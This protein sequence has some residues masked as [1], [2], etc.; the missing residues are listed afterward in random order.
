MKG[1]VMDDMWKKIILTTGSV[2]V[3]GLLFSILMKNMFNDKIVNLLGPGNLFYILVLLISVFFIALVL[4]ILKPKNAPQ[5]P[6]E[7]RS[8]EP[9]KNIH[10]EY[11]DSTH[12]GNN[13]F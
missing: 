10:I 3:V 8:N 5:V 6:R 4:A 12:N 2:G 1:S 11:D 7:P 9:A 13:T